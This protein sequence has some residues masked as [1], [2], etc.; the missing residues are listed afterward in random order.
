MARDNK[1]RAGN[2]QGERES[3]LLIGGT[4]TKTI[5]IPLLAESCIGTRFGHAVDHYDSWQKI[6]KMQDFTPGTAE[7]FG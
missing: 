7:I 4:E 6:Y 2:D 3:I 1:E 5:F